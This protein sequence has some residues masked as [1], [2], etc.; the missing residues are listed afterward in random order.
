MVNLS[1]MTSAMNQPSPNDPAS[2]DSS[3]DSPVTYD[4]VI[5]WDIALTHDRNNDLRQKS[6]VQNFFDL[7]STIKSCLDPDSTKWLR[8]LPYKMRNDAIPLFENTSDKDTEDYQLHLSY[9]WLTVDK[10]AA[11][12]V[13]GFYH[14]PCIQNAKPEETRLFIPLGR[15]FVNARNGG[16]CNTRCNITR[17][18]VTRWTG[19]EVFISDDLALWIV[20]DYHCLTSGAQPWYPVSCA[21]L[22][23]FKPRLSIACLLPSLAT[24]EHATFQTAMTSLQQTYLDLPQ[25]QIS[26]VERSAMTKRSLFRSFD[27]IVRYLEHVRINNRVGHNNLAYHLELGILKLRL[28]RCYKGIVSG[29]LPHV[30]GFSIENELQSINVSLPGNVQLQGKP[31]TSFDNWMVKELDLLS[32]KYYNHDPTKSDLTGVDEG[33]LEDFRVQI[34]SV[35]KLLEEASMFG[36]RY[37]LGDIYTMRCQDSEHIRCRFEATA[38]DL[39]RL[40]YSAQTV[41]REFAELFDYKISVNAG[42]AEVEGAASVTYEDVGNGGSQGMENFRASYDTQVEGRDS[43]L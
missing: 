42:R 18:R 11:N 24:V 25:V 37:D 33:I 1:E 26:Q 34:L 36:A 4:P 41:D 17:S 39:Q 5:E 32:Q 12:P 31:S 20:F 7:A 6:S 10:H 27:K 14:L 15:L 21:I 23:P 38:A 22:E 29:E 3:S 35:T 19:Y 16:S 2:D 28:C 43:L 30:G 8:S 9:S 40:Q 13:P